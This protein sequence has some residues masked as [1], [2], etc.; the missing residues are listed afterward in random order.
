[1][2]TVLAWSKDVEVSLACLVQLKYQKANVCVVHLG[3]D[4]G[5]ALLIKRWV[6]YYIEQMQQFGYSHTVN[7][8]LQSSFNNMIPSEEGVRSGWEQYI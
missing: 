4:L 5:S 6:E 7:K 3:L 1:M 2:L 8:N